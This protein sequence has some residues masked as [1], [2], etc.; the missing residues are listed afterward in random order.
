MARAPSPIDA[1]LAV[2]PADRRDALERLRRAIHAAA[3]GAEECL[4]YRIPAFRVDGEVVAGFLA[5]AKGCSYFPFSGTV[6]AALAGEVAGYGGT[7]GSL[8]FSPATGL[9]AALVRKLVRARQVE[10]KEKVRGRKVRAGK[11]KREG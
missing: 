5:T 4:S 6:L 10:V 1:Y 3:P 9:P 8:H 7:R 2:V 11:A